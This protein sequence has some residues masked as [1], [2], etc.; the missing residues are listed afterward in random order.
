[1][2]TT[3]N[4]PIGVFD[5]GLGGLTVLK[6]IM[7][8]L[9]QESTIYF[10]DS[11]R[12]PYGSK[13]PE[14][15]IKFSRQIVRFLLAKQVKMI[16]IA[17]NTASSFAYEDV[18]AYAG[19]P[20]VEVI[21][22]GARAAVRQSEHGR[23]GVIGTRGT[24]SSG[25]YDRAI[26]KAAEENQTV[27]QEQPPLILQQACP[28]FV[29]LAEE[30]WWDQE[31]TRQIAAIYLKPLLERQIDTLVLGC[32]HYPLLS[33][34]IAAVAGPSIKLVEAGR[35]VAEQVRAVLAENQL[36]NDSKSLAVHQYYTSDSVEQF[37]TLGGSFLAR[38]ID[39]ATRIDIE[40]YQVD[41][42][43]IKGE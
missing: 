13:S 4:R 14:T 19:V 43:P 1:M 25:V 40:Q 12:T 6:E 29:S 22:P 2:M 17:C 18:C 23:I 9:P 28:L 42:D 32:T 5:S 16:V 27:A 11:G 30:G 41:S 34:A 38:S 21:G 15:I 31:I 8:L 10:G 35:N 36:C 26:R 33:H 20:V 3:D 39:Q 7:D 37:R 24:V